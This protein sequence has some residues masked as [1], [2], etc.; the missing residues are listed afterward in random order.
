MSF[1][2]HTPEK[3]VFRNLG[4]RPDPFRGRILIHTPQF[5]PGLDW[6]ARNCSL[7]L[8]MV[9][10]PHCAPCFPA[11]RVPA[12]RVSLLQILVPRMPPL[13]YRQAT[14]RAMHVAF[15]TV[16]RLNKLFLARTSDIERG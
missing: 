13:R 6:S 14:L 12:S 7:D 15:L 8:A 16:G 3:H 5:E 1:V 4:A 9:S 11:I 10:L 2:L